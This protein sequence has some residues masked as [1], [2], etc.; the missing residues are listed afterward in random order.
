MGNGNI[1]KTLSAT[2][3][4]SKIGRHLIESL[5]ESVFLDFQFRCGEEE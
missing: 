5:S 1:F 2:K 3:A 4:F